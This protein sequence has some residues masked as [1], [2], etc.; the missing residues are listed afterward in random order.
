L[1]RPVSKP[2]PTERAAPL[3]KLFA[4][5]FGAFLALALLKFSTPPVMERLVVTPSGGFEWAISTWPVALGH[6]MLVVVALAGLAVFRMPPRPRLWI[7]AL[8]GLWLLWQ[9]LAAT[10]TVDAELTRLTLKHFAACVACFYLGFGC[11][12]REG[13][14]SHFLWP[15]ALAFA[16]VLAVGFEQH[17]GGLEATRKYFFTYVYPTLD[18]VPPEYLKK[19]Q[20]NRIFSTVFYPNALAGALLLLLPP[21]VAWNWQARARFT[22]GAR[23]FLCGSL[24]AGALLCLYWSGSK[25][26]W[27]LALLLTCVVLLNQRLPALLKWG[28]IGLLLVG[29]SLGLYLKNRAYVERGATSVVARFDYWRAV[30]QTVAAK[31][32][33]G[34]GPGTFGVAYAA[35]KKP[36]SEMARLA[37]NDYLQQ[38]S[39]SGL[40]G[41]LLYA[42]FVSSVLWAGFVSFRAE[43]TPVY[44]GAWLGLLVWA[45]QGLGEFTLYVP[46]V[47]WPAFA[48]LGWQLGT[49]GKPF[50][51]PAP[52]V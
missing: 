10:Q 39:D 43:R 36:G 35:V 9:F 44:F 12:N 42:G 31:P 41:C 37:H 38:A 45:L 23:L 17:F 3:P 30:G 13:V 16:V 8:P 46:G 49:S 28:L 27:L 5:V 51:K 24:L 26:G 34:S 18:N 40:L 15:I 52:A 11:L 22:I 14:T 2:S 32:L 19:M 29:G 25:G 7:A 50:D 20:S 1:T 4:A 48:F 21:V 6:G 47:A 33:F